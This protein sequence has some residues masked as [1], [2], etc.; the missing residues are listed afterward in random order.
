[1]ARKYLK[2]NIRDASTEET[3]LPPKATA[4]ILSRIESQRED[5]KW[6]Q[7][8]R[9]F[10]KPWIENKEP[11]GYID[12]AEER[13]KFKITYTGLTTNLAVDLPKSKML[14]NEMKDVV[15]IYPEVITPPFAFWFNATAILENSILTAMSYMTN[16]TDTAIL[17]YAVYNRR[18]MLNLWTKPWDI[19]MA[20]SVT[21][22]MPIEP[23]LSLNQH[24][25]IMLS[26]VEAYIIDQ[27]FK[28]CGGKIPFIPNAEHREKYN[29]DVTTMMDQDIHEAQIDINAEYDTNMKKVF[30]GRSNTGT[31]YARPVA[32]RVCFLCDNLFPDAQTCIS[33]HTDK[34]TAR[35]AKIEYCKYMQ[36]L[37]SNKPVICTQCEQS[38]KKKEDI[39]IHRVYF[40]IA[41]HGDQRLPCTACNCVNCQCQQAK[42]EMFE[43]VKE[44]MQSEPNDSIWW[45]NIA[46]A[47]IL[48]F[49][50]LRI[51]HATHI[52]IQ[53][54]ADITRETPLTKKQQK[55]EKM[56]IKLD[57]MITL[58]KEEGAGIRIVFRY[59]GLDRYEFNLLMK[60][61]DA[62]I[63]RQ[64]YDVTAWAEPDEIDETWTTVPDPIRGVVCEI[65][66]EIEGPEHE[67][68]N[69]PICW[70]FLQT[71]RSK[72]GIRN[73][74]AISIEEHVEHLNTHRANVTCFICQ[75][76][77]QSQGEF[78]THMTIHERYT[79]IPL[80]FPSQAC[81]TTESQQCEATWD[82][83][84]RFILHNILLHNKK[85]G[86][87]EE[88][89][90]FTQNWTQIETVNKPTAK[91]LN[92]MR[93][94]KIIPED[95]KEPKYEEEEDIEEIGL[96]AI[97]TH[98]TKLTYKYQCQQTICQK[99][100]A[101]TQ[102]R[103]IHYMTH[104]KCPI[105][106]T[107]MY[108][109]PYDDAM[110][111]HIQIMH[112]TDED[113]RCRHCQKTFR[114]E[115]EREEHENLHNVNCELCGENFGTNK[116]KNQHEER[117]QS[118]SESKEKC[119]GTTEVILSKALTLICKMPDIDNEMNKQL[120]EYGDQLD[121]AIVEKCKTEKSN[122]RVT[123]RGV[124]GDSILFLDYP[125]F[126]K[127]PDKFKSIKPDPH[128]LK[129]I[130][131]FWPADKNQIHANFL[132]FVGLRNINITI[133]QIVKTYLLTEY[134]AISI[135]SSK[136][137][138][139]IK[140]E[141]SSYHS[142]NWACLSYAQM[143]DA[144]TILFCPIVGAE[145][146]AASNSLPKASSETLDQYNGRIFTVLDVCSLRVDDEDERTDWI[147]KHQRKLLMKYLPV[148][149]RRDI[150]REESTTGAQYTIKELIEAHKSHERDIVKG[151]KDAQGPADLS[152][153]IGG[154][155][156]D[157]NYT[158]SEI[159]S[160]RGNR[161]N[162]GTRTRFRN[163]ASRTRG[164][165]TGQNRPTYAIRGIG[166][167]RSRNRG[168]RTNTRTNRY[169][170]GTHTTFGLPQDNSRPNY[171]QNR[172]RS[173]DR[174]I[175]EFGRSRPRGRSNFRGN[176]RGNSR[177]RSMSRPRNVNQRTQNIQ[178]E[179]NKRFGVPLGQNF[180]FN[181][182]AGTKQYK[183][184]P[185]DSQH[186]FMRDCKIYKV[187][188]KSD[189][190]S[191]ICEAGWHKP[192]TCKSRK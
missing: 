120:K 90:K 82:S 92:K 20:M 161:G 150:M 9:G 24:C 43:M 12:N 142:T 19:F 1:M 26:L 133:S 79:I 84:I 4:Y 25:A 59:R 169:Q 137:P 143:L 165:Y 168:N 76:D 148:P 121:N 170:R 123:T 56:D 183:G 163:R 16:D 3:I 55:W 140:N 134:Q 11:P 153:L 187:D 109:S 85:E 145:L 129:N 108:H 190:L 75:T 41:K 60:N 116:L 110:L 63:I 188:D 37:D 34:V 152:Q 33:H 71:C 185:E 21:G 32:E 13:D 45:D 22:N 17:K 7:S 111:A 2:T 47:N 155:P 67:I 184:R 102:A 88:L 6:W 192:T 179:A 61:A 57:N 51:I 177:P 44:K 162:R 166:R 115:E 39:L 136:T 147:K 180:C 167:G 189:N 66:K 181:C 95:V 31:I 77:I 103:T 144:L 91:E 35:R 114:T 175:S 97:S 174:T 138:D 154:R 159:G 191:Q 70:C 50:H 104:H 125:S 27:P 5:F 113:N 80:W 52:E 23:I 40:C 94:K 173:R 126:N 122:Q 146:D 127:S 96:T 160:N 78:F 141:V 107:C 131:E 49:L 69:H 87:F 62:N 124:Y 101:T 72:T 14:E 106:R 48:Q 54:D 28:S 98:K 83:P 149:L 81:H 132:N 8:N 105:D 178:Q 58:T 172:S 10:D 18:H 36:L 46:I 156:H 112:T 93:Y 130:N 157:N 29:M 65:C 158:L 139:T 171:N 74:R 128:I 38:F 42:L 118:V 53:N 117:C 182:M 119:A 15:L 64:T 186:K 30:K 99:R 100:F 164:N 135:I 151:R 86:D 176:S 89:I 68:N 73:R